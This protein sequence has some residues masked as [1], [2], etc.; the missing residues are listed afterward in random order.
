[1]HTPWGRAQDVEELADGVFRVS[2]ASHGGLKLSR[3]RWEEIPEQVRNVFLNPLYAE[4]DCEEPIALSLLGLADDH[5]RDRA[6]RI[7]QAF[8]RYSIALFILLGIN[9]EA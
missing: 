6:L 3:E 2:T 5:D 7:A 1:M 4:E 9:R 8:D